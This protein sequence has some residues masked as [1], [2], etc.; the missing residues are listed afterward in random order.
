MVADEPISALDVSIQS[1]I[2]NLMI[3]PQKELGLTYLFITHDISV[4]KYI[5]DEGAVMYLGEVVERADK[6]T[7]FHEPLHPYTK[8]LLKAVPDISRPFLPED[9]LI[10]GEIPNPTDLPPSC[11]FVPRC[12]YALVQCRAAHPQFVEKDAG[13][14]SRSVRCIPS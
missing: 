1:Q 14:G 6:K 13:F 11:F 5:S 2:L 3:D 8:L 4:V 9:V 10:S 7:L 12:P